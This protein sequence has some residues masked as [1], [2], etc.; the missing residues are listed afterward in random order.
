M[1]ILFQSVPTAAFLLASHVLAS[2][3]NA[4]CPDTDQAPKLGA[5]ACENAVCSHIGTDLLQRG[6]NAVDAIVGTVFC[7]GTVHMYHS[8][9]GGGGFMVVRD[10]DGAYETVNFRE[11]APAAAHRDMYEGNFDA[12]LTGGLAR[13]VDLRTCPLP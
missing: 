5:V 3:Q 8:G 13:Y 12:S 9:I 7:V 4:S 6:G 11:M 2:A 10:S 1:K